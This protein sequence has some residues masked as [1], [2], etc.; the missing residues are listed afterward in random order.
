[1]ASGSGAV[2]EKRE[3]NAN[4]A[5]YNGTYSL[6]VVTNKAQTEKFVNVDVTTISGIKRASQLDLIGSG[7]AQV[8]MAPDLE[9]VTEH[10]LS[11]RLDRSAKAFALF[12]HPIERAVSLFHYLQKA[13]WEPT[14]DP[15]LIDMNIVDWAMSGK[16]ENNWMTRTLVGDMDTPN[17]DNEHLE[18]AKD[19]VRR[20]FVVGLMDEMEESWSRFRKYFQWTRST[21]ENCDACLKEL[22]KSGTNLNKHDAIEKGSAEWNALAKINEW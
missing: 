2:L 19:V 5:T 7:L 22:F 13:Y 15:L 3:V 9:I 17:L 10:L 14:Y 20:K 21:N 18:L 11:S 12:R 16:A 8:I 6:R 1:M 4:A